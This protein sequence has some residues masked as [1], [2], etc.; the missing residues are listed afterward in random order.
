MKIIK[1]PSNVVLCSR[2]EA[3]L[4]FEQNDVQCTKY[5]KPI[6]FIICPCCG[7]VIEVWS[8]KK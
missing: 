3:V 7:H 6:R 4:G 2:C 8:G 5:G 1:E